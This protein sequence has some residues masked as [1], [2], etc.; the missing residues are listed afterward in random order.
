MENN[1]TM[2][3]FFE[4]IN[5][6]CIFYIITI[7]QDGSI[8][9]KLENMRYDDYKIT[10]DTTNKIIIRVHKSKHKPYYF[11]DF[12]QYFKKTTHW[13]GFLMN[14]CC[15]YEICEAETPDWFDADF[16]FNKKEEKL[17]IKHI[18]T[19]VFL[20]LQDFLSGFM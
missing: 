18:N 20:G 8:H 13:K 7:Q 15:C 3:D 10:S 16:Y 4:F 2:N 12:F 9:V 6:E 17:T 5:Q 1:N 11:L 19:D 14:S